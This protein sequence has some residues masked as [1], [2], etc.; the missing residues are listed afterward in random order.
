[1]TP[2]RDPHPR[3]PGT[4]PGAGRRWPR[5]RRE[6]PGGG[7]PSSPPWAFSTRGTWP[8]WTG[9]RRWR[10]TVLSIFVNPLQFG[11]GEDLDRYPRD[12]ERDLARAGD[13]G[14]PTWPSPPRW[15]SCIPRPPHHPV[16]PGPW[17][18]RLC[19]AFRPGHFRG[20]LTVVARLFGLFRPDVAVFGRKDASRR[21]WSGRWSGTWR[22][23]WRWRWPP[24]PGGRRP[25]HE[26]PE[27][28]PG[29]R[30]SGGGAGPLPGA[31]GGGGRV[32]GGERD[33]RVLADR[34]RAAL[35]GKEGFRLEYAEV[36]DPE[37]AG[38][39]RRGRPGGGRPGGGGVAG[40]DPAH[41]QPGAGGRGDGTPGSG[42]A[43][44]LPG[45][46]LRPRRGIPT[47]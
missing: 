31:G 23:G 21:P 30:R 24:G 25:G 4:P 16:D 18:E 13:A 41:R 20:V 12:L 17:G 33:R 28:L 38:G 43:P 2:G 40:A 7:W 1:M 34:V 27:R 10:T 11:P 22:W 5:E 29:P 46:F 3:G 32:P 14:A 26:L 8:S 37:T 45:G 47:P 15:R 36:V 42:R 9:P 6:G 35:E 19:G 39:R 44:P